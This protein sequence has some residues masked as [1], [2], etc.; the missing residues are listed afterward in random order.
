MP[1]EMKRLA[2]GG[3]ET[4]APLGNAAVL[5]IAVVACTGFLQEQAPPAP[6]GLARAL[7]A[8]RDSPPSWK[9]DDA[10]NHRV[11]LASGTFVM[12]ADGADAFDNER[13]LHTVTLSSFYIQEHEVTNEEYQRFEPS[14]SFEPGRERHPAILNWHE[15]TDY[16]TWLGGRLPTEAQWEY[17]A[18]GTEGRKYPWGSEEPT[19]DHAN[20]GRNVGEYGRTTP[21]ATYPKGVT[22]EGLFDLAGNVGEWC[23]DWL[24]PYPSDVQTDPTG[25]TDEESLWSVP[26]KGPFRVLRGGNFRLPGTYLRGSVRH[27]YRP[28]HRNELTGFRVVWTERMESDE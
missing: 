28:E 8:T 2:D 12:G 19:P 9:D 13:P 24:G 10:L 14:H 6:D 20:F 21:V 5:A 25:A 15:A 23:A 7:A 26:L 16:A 11:L 3:A 27:G 4:T 1:E 17:A 18:R 22:P